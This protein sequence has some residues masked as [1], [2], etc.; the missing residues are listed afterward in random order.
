MELFSTRTASGGLITKLPP[1]DCPPD[2][3]LSYR[4]EKVPFW[5][6]EAPAWAKLDRT[7]PQYDL[8]VAPNRKHTP[9]LPRLIGFGDA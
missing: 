3:F 2:E 9:E 1:P 6:H 8:Y 5:R 7:A 4:N